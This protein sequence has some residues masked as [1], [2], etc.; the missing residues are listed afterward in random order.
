VGIELIIAGV[1]VGV[2][3]GATGMGAGSLMAPL[4][5]TFFNVPALSVVGTDLLYSGAS[6][7]VGAWRHRSLNTVNT[8]LAWWMASGSVPASLVGIAVLHRLADAEG[9][10]IQKDVRYGIGVALMAV[11]PSRSARS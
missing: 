1:V 6:K 7:A 3:V 10:T 5:I 11:R 4:L 8:Q 9:A 2:L